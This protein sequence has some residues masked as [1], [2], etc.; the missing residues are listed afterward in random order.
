MRLWYGMVGG[1]AA[2][3]AHSC[4]EQPSRSQIRDST[5]VA[6]ERFNNDDRAKVLKLEK[7]VEVGDCT[8]WR[9]TDTDGTHYIAEGRSTSWT[10]ANHAQ[11]ALACAITR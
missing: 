1:F 9:F 11:S 10:P 7:V 8:V 2:F 6:I 4:T 5:A 3:V